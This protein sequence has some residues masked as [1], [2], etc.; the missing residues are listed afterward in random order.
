[1]NSGTEHSEL[2]DLAVKKLSGEASANELNQLQGLIDEKAENQTLYEELKKTWISTEKARG[3]TQ[4]EVDEEWTRLRKE[5]NRD[6]RKSS[7]PNWLKIAASLALVLTVSLVI[8]Q[9]SKSDRVTLVASNNTVTKTLSDGTVV[10]LNSNSELQYSEGFSDEVR[11]VT[12]EGEAFFEAA[13]DAE[14]PFIVH[15]PSIDV[16]VLGTSF[17]VRADASEIADVIVVEGLVSVRFDEKE[18]KLSAGEKAIALLTSDNLTKVINDNPNFLSWKTREFYFDDTPLKQVVKDLNH[19]FQSSIQVEDNLINCPVTV[20]F[21]G[22][23]LDSIL[24]VLQATLNL[25]IHENKGVK[26]LSGPGC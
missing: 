26:V 18:V 11:E 3:I 25:S 4:T 8:F 22:Q 16:R 2:I 12:L 9:L 15:T 19:A 24:M 1:M 23:S 10:T 21:E 20:S 14:R 7:F 17:S 6:E 5:M 13:R